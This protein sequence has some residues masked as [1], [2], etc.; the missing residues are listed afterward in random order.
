MRIHF[1]YVGV[2]NQFT[3]TNP[4][5]VEAVDLVSSYFPPTRP[6]PRQ[7]DPNSAMMLETG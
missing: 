7:Y 5:V 6:F 1:H 2:Q 3:K 4:L